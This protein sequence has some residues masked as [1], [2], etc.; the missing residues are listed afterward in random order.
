[1]Q[2]HF[3]RSIFIITF[4]L[5]SF[6]SFSQHSKEEPKKFK[7]A[8]IP[9][10]N[11]NKTTGFA[12]GAITQGFYKLNSKDTISPTSSTG[13]MGIYT[14]NNTYFATVFQRLYLKEDRWRVMFFGGTGNVNFQ[15]WQQFFDLGGAFIGYA[16][17]LN[18]ASLKV[19]R[20][21]YKEL[22]F[23]VRAAFTE[24]KTSFEVPQWVPDSIKST[25]VNMNNVGYLFNYDRREHQLNPFGGFNIE[26]K[27]FFYN[28]ALGSDYD[29]G[30]IQFTYNHYYPIKNNR[31]ILATRATANLSYGKVPFQ[32][33]NIVGQDD[34]RGYTAGKYRENQV[35]ALQAEYRWRFYKKFGMVAFFGVA[36]AVDQFSSLAS[37]EILPGGGIGLRYQMIESERINIGL[38]IAQ[39]KDDWGI[40][41]RIGESFGR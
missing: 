20:K 12:L 16:N 36:S 9:M 4:L 30:K 11:Y 32:G 5:T 38:D 28:Q 31:N 26:F 22:Y 35:Y 34:I 1:M 2:S 33:Q 21:V 7:F 25:V 37:S 15:Y 13:V 17:Q 40:Y 18:F 3:V 8:A 23:G 29:F 6:F 14:T 41:F 27:H 39:G 10:V 24:S 19:E